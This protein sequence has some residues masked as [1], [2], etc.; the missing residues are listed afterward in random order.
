[1]AANSGGRDSAG[2][3]AGNGSAG[4][5]SG[6]G[7]AANSGSGA[8]AS[9]TGGNGAAAGQAAGPAAG[10]GDTVG[11]LA[12][13]TVLVGVGDAALRGRSAD[14]SNWLY[15]ANAA[16]HQGEAV[17]LL[18][19]TGYGAGVFIAVGGD[20]NN[21]MVMRS[22]D[23]EH[24]QE[25]VHPTTACKG[26]AYPSSC[27]NWMGGVAYLDGTWLAGGGNGAMMRSTD[28]GAS[29]TG[30][31]AGFPEKHIRSIGAGSGR[32]LAGTD[33]GG[34]AVSK[35]QGD[36]WTAKTPW[37][38]APSNAVLQFAYGN[39]SF[40]AF[41]QEDIAA[42]QRACFVSSN[43]GDDWQACDASVKSNV[44]FVH[45]GTRWVTSA[46]GGYATST[47]AK[48]WTSHT[49]S[50]VPSQLL[51]DG[52]TWFGRTGGTVYRGATLDSFA[53]VATKVSDF[54]AWTLGAV[55]ATN[56]PVMGVAA[57]SAKP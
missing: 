55:L 41:T 53:S 8:L 47:D 18:R 37:S 49:A 24:W 6:A 43:L 25:D 38:S 27:T 26:E 35:D 2:N 20:T 48:T 42:G 15:C 45:D 11:P 13:A 33:G 28:V 3:A 32:F 46:N 54:R 36:S 40:I 9:G 23:G 16:S 21:G 7:P 5:G 57:C 52:K 34:L 10:S 30:L 12:G 29:W 39:G 51:F 22:L 4:T 50:N 31:H 14:G 44:S 17:D 1:M 19:N 56:L